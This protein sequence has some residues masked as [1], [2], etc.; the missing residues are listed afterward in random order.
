MITDFFI[1]C[2]DATNEEL[3]NLERRI[4]GPSSRRH[5]AASLLEDAEDN[6]DDNYESDGNDGSAGEWIL[7]DPKNIK[8]PFI[9]SD[10]KEPRTQ[11]PRLSVAV[12]LPSGAKPSSVTCRIV[13][14]GQ[15]LQISLHLPDEMVI[16][17]KLHRL[18][19]NHNDPNLKIENYHPKII[20]F[21]ESLKELRSHH[22]ER[23]EQ[24]M[25]IQLPFSVETS[26]HKIT[27]LGWVNSK[28]VVLYCDLKSNVDNY[29]SR[30]GTTEIELS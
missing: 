4:T 16:M 17:E 12:L 2:I 27:N 24:F 13:D 14:S 26:I 25:R 10:W 11:V 3:N 30:R 28:A 7:S 29:G 21:E 23:V 1:F 6:D 5:S 19:I 15:V 18:W 20:G 8:M 22:S 9:M